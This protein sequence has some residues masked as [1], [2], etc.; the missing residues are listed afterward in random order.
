MKNAMKTLIACFV[1]LISA[2]SFAQHVKKERGMS[3]AQ[4][5]ENFKK[6]ATELNLSEEQ[7][8]EVK[9]ILL[10]QRKQMRALGEERKGL[11]TM[12]EVEKK[13][14][15][16]EIMLRRSEI[17]NNTSTRL[18]SVLEPEQ[19]KMYLEMKENR[20]AKMKHARKERVK[21]RPMKQGEM[22]QTEES[23]T[24]VD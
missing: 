19:M 12:G 2:P 21:H 13:E 6:M 5:K 15:R 10:E 16:E 1:I 7:N 23:G 4:V 8:T 11:A 9:E 20:R 17:E 22:H 24:S 3:E 14:A 18:A